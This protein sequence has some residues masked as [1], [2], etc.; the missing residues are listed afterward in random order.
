MKKLFVAGLVLA[1]LLSVSFLETGSVYAKD[2]HGR[3]HG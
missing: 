2:G 3:G 1:V